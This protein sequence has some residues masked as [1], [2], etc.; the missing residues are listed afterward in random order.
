MWNLPLPV[1][2][3]QNGFQMQNSSD[4]SHVHPVAMEIIK[5]KSDCSHAA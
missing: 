2:N 4:I 1:P 3:I 5:K